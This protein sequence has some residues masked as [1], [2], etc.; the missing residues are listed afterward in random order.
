MAGKGLGTGLGA[1][2]GD[3]AMEP[4]QDKSDFL[5]ISLIEP[6]QDQPRRVFDESQLSELADSIAEHGVIQPITVRPIDG[7]YYQI[8]AGERRWR[9]ARM[10]G[11]MQVP[12][13][14]IEAD[15]KKAMVL[16]MVENLQR[17]DL[18]PIEEAKGYQKLIDE[19]GM[20]QARLA[21]SVGK[22]RPVI[23]NSLRLLTLPPEIISLTEEGKLSLSQARALLEV[24]GDREKI[25]I[26][27]KA[28][29]YGL[30]VREIS[31][32]A[33]KS[34]KKRGKKPPEHRVSSDGVDY[35]AEVEKTLSNALGR[36]VKII[37]G[38]KKGK[39]EIEYYDENDFEEICSALSSA[40]NDMNTPKN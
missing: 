6:R 3:S 30:T 39:I 38:R 34:G 24:E 31:V 1:L 8:I 26:G 28:A 40:G 25:E 18:N 12:C 37:C 27:Q 22:S 16:A 35:Y 2:F 15:D 11:L 33:A 4:E 7:G 13:R 36:K 14:I 32:L 17:E 19:Y 23:T 10:A 9:A 20:T 29:D 21:D 5:P